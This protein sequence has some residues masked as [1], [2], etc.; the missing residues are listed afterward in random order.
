VRLLR[1]KVASS[2]KKTLAALR[3][4]DAW[5]EDQGLDPGDC[6]RGGGKRFRAARTAPAAPPDSCLHRTRACRRAGTLEQRIGRFQ[7]RECPKRL[8]NRLAFCKALFSTS[9][10]LPAAS[11]GS[12]TPHGLRMGDGREPWAAGGALRREKAARWR[13]AGIVVVWNVL[14]NL[15]FVG[16][17]AQL[18]HARL[19]PIPPAWSIFDVE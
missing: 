8:A 9:C 16:C 7:P 3:R 18:A 5:I 17:T 14:G 13:V 11:T 2:L 12:P 15:Q 4:I 19:H 1:P 10:G 6:E